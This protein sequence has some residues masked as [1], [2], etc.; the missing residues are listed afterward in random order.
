MQASILAFE[1]IAIVSLLISFA[2]ALLLW[3]QTKGEAER[4][5]QLANSAFSHIKAKDL[6]E[7]T[8][9][10]AND[11]Q[12]ANARTGLAS[13]N[14]KLQIRASK[15]RERA[16]LRGVDNGNKAAC[17]ILQQALRLD[18]SSREIKALLENCN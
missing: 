17:D 12:R 10:A 3:M 2:N 7:V 1:I 16:I 5:A 6:G 11:A 14:N 8:A 15:Y 4:L 9:K 13:V 18:P